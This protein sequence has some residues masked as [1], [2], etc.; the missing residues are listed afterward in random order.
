MILQ[1]KGMI[2]MPTET[3]KNFR[4]Q[5]KEYSKR[6]NNGKN[7]EFYSF[8][9]KDKISSYYDKSEKRKKVIRTVS[10]GG[11]LVLI[12][13]IY[14]I[15]TWIKPAI[16]SFTDNKHLQISNVVDNKSKKHREIANYLDLIEV[17]KDKLKQYYEYWCK[18]V[19]HAFENDDVIFFDNIEEKSTL[20]K[21]LYFEIEE[22]NSPEEPK[23][24]KELELKNFDNIYEIFMAT[25][26]SYYTNNSEEKK[27]NI[28]R[29]SKLVD[30]ANLYNNKIIDELI[31]V[32]N[33]IDM[34]YERTDS[35]SIR[36]WWKE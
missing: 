4:K 20:I 8:I 28:E 30:E 12:W 25:L 18:N 33:E 31:R 7:T 16:Y 32:F 10:I 11:V 9:K 22:L 21:E 3:Q 6:N 26:I 29:C 5:M 34:K 17:K 27:D 15:Y 2:F 24:Y 35:G 1:L 14:A 23:V 19:N 36:Y 13:N